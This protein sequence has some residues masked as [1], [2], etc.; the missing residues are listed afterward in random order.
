MA[1]D[2]KSSRFLVNRRGK[3]EAVILSLSDYRK[4]LRLAEDRADVTILDRAKRTT[5]RLISH[6]ELMQRLGRQRLI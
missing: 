5:R 4:L 3:P 1:I 2:L 6:A